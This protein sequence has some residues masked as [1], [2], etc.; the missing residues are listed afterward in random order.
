MTCNSPSSLAYDSPLLYFVLS[1]P[2]GVLSFL[3]SLLATVLHPL[4]TTFLYCILSSLDLQECWASHDLQKPYILGLQQSFTVF[5]PLLTCRST[6]LLMT[7]KSPSSL[8]H[9]TDLLL[10]FVL[11]WT[12]G[13]LSLFSHMTCN[14]SFILSLQQ[15]FMYC[16]FSSLDLQKCK[17]FWVSWLATVLQPWPTT[18][19]TVFCLWPVLSFLSLVTFNPFAPTRRFTVA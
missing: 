13:V 15:S 9:T 14:Q 4:P 12:A 5:C 19:F 1:W 16:I 17:A 8:A 11:S 18:V 10:Y 6:K 7:C 2:A 3:S